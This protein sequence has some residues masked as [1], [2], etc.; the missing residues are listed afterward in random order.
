MDVDSG[1]SHRLLR[2]LVVDTLRQG[3]NSGRYW[4]AISVGLGGG[5]GYSISGSFLFFLF[6]FW[7]LKY[8]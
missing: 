4:G 6:S 8:S 1:Q 2:F 5:D 3:K 7:V